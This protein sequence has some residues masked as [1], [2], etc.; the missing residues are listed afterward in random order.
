MTAAVQ[1]KRRFDFGDPVLSELHVLEPVFAIGTRGSRVPSLV[2]LALTLPR[3]IDLDDS[4]LQQLDEEWR[5]LG[6]EDLPENIKKKH[7][8]ANR[9]KSKINILIS[10]GAL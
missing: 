6:M 8:K 4:T 10:F 1:I 7:G 3:I 5:K 2:L 9:K